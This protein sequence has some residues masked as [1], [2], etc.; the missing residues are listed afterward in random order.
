M[1]KLAIAE[2]SAPDASHIKAVNETW[3]IAAY[4]R[5]RRRAVARFVWNWIK[6][7]WMTS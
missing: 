5:L 2:F 3:D 6:G 1:T 7:R 4:H